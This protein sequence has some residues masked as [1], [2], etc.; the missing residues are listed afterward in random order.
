MVE[1]WPYPSLVGHTQTCELETMGWKQNEQNTDGWT[2]DDKAMHSQLYHI[3]MM[4]IIFEI[5]H[6]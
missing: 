6:N 2:N 3:S 4:K 5:V 1:W